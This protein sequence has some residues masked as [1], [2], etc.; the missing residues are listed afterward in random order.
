MSQERLEKIHKRSIKIKRLSE[1][2]SF[3]EEARNPRIVQCSEKR[4][5]EPVSRGGK[6]CSDIHCPLSFFLMGP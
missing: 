5:G 1:I 3:Y 4:A 6:L 2:H